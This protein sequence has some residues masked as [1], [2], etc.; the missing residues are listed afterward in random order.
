MSFGSAAEK[1]NLEIDDIKKF[2]NGEASVKVNYSPRIWSSNN[3]YK[4][5]AEANLY[6]FVPFVLPLQKNHLR[7][8]WTLPRLRWKK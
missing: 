4:M 5:L 1:K 6:D 7:F 2:V 3:Y 8:S